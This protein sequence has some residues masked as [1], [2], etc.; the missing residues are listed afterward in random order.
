MDLDDINANPARL[1][2]A[3]HSRLGPVDGPVPVREIALALDIVEIC[4]EPFSNLE[5]TLLT[6]LNRSAIL[7]NAAS[8]RG[9]IP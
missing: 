9:R 4:C 3:I 8:N 7:I 6:D 5:G 2:E 1:A